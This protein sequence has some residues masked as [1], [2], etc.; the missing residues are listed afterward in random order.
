TAGNSDSTLTR[1]SVV[2]DNN[3]PNYSNV[4]QTKEILRAGENN[5]VSLNVWEPKDASGIDRVEIKYRHESQEEVSWIVLD[6]TQSR[7]FTFIYNDLINGTYYW[8][9]EIYDKAGNV[10]TTPTYSFEVITTEIDF[11]III[12]LAIFSVVVIGTF[13]GSTLLLKRRK[14]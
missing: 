13:T 11:D 1:T 9:F 2:E 3:P 4:N 7:S 12:P 10:L 5:T 14:N 8:F 6:V